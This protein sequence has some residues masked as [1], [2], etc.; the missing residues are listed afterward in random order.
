MKWNKLS[1]ESGEWCLKNVVW[2]AEFKDGIRITQSF[3]E[4]IDSSLY[5][6]Y[7]REKV[8][9]VSIV[10]RESIWLRSMSQ[11]RG[12]ER[13][14]QDGW[15]RPLDRMLALNPRSIPQ[16]GSYNTI[17]NKKIL[18]LGGSPMMDPPISK[19]VSCGSKQKRSKLLKGIIY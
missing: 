16:I 1:Q 13:R 19:S 18:T 11:T 3:M 10:V 9:K 14:S 4:E 6:I 12:R 2:K 5:G 7:L 8:G 15:S 17:K